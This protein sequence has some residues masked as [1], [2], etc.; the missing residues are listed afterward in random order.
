MELKIRHELFA[1][2]AN[3]EKK[4]TSRLGVRDVKPGEPLKFVSN[5]DEK[6]VYETIVESVKVCAFADITEEDAHMEGYT[7]LGEMEKSLRAVYDF[8]SH[9]TFTLIRFR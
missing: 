7:S 2:I 4:S 8:D 9:S 6:L 1:K 5:D 3:G